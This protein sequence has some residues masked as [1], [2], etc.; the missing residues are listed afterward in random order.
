[1]VF[2]K[3]KNWLIDVLKGMSLGLGMVPGVS[4]GT[5]ALIVNIYKRLVDG[6]ADLFKHF[7]ENFLSLLPLGIGTIIG[8][9]AI[10]FGVRY[11]FH[12]APVA[13]VSLFAGTIIGFIPLIQKEIKNQKISAKPILLIVFSAFFAASIG[14]LSALAKFYWNFSLNDAFLQNQWWIY[15]LVFVAGFIASAACII[16]GISG[17]MILFIL[18]L[19]NPILEIFIGPNSLFHNHDR[20]LSGLLITLVL[21]FGIFIGLVS[22]SKLMKSL[23]EKHHDATYNVVIG[24]IIGSIVSMFIN[25]E[26]VITTESSSYFV[27]QNTSPVEWIIATILFVASLLLCFSLCRRLTLKNN[28]IS[29]GDNN[30]KNDD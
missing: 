9:I 1:M 24:F 30:L 11:G 5:M 28:K 29:E 20:L 22:I 26:M 23:L 15:P 10:T 13:I 4:A 6:I 14:I 27:Y 2:M 12:Y 19:Y 7:K 25:Q 3:F 21:L 8:A 18:G 17:S 16:P